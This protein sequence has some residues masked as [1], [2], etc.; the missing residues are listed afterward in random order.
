MDRRG[1][2]ASRDAARLHDRGRLRRRRRRGR[3]RRGAHRWTDRPVGPLLRG[4]LRDGRRRAQRQRQPPRP[5]RAEPRPAAIRRARSTRIEAALAGGD[6]DAAIV[7][8]LVDI[9]EMTAE[10]IDAF[11]ADPL[12]PVRLAAA[13][14]V[15]RECRVE[16]DW[17]YRPGQFDTITAPTL[18]LAG[19]DSVPVI[20]E[21]TSGRRPRSPTPRS[22]SSRGTATSPTRPTRRWSPT[23]SSGSWHRYRCQWPRLRRPRSR[24][25]GAPSAS[26]TP[27][28]CTSRRPAP[29]SSTSS[30]T[31]SPSAPASST[32]CASGRAC[33]TAS[34]P[35]VSGEKVHQKRVP[36]GAPPWLETVRLHFPRYGLHA[37]ELCVTELAEVIWAVQMSTVEFHPWNSRR[38]DVEQPDEWRI[39]LDPMPDCPLGHGAARRPRRPRGAR[40]ARRRRLAE[41][42]RRQGPARLRAHRADARVHRRAPGRAGL[43]PRGRAPRAATR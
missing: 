40:R 23:S 24:S 30:S 11:R 28:G 12:W 10:E 1:F 27:T 29:R 14:T 39:D 18:M 19:S 21:A 2:G 9:L 37:D 7:A 38:A 42:V 32:R 6:H 31:T 26:P 8:V 43:R 33:C 36:A 22:S 15:P 17:V 13:P 5:V 25:A 20:V 34:R 3:C 35:G 4:Q 41:D 16:Q